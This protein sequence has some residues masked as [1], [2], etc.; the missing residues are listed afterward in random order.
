MVGFMDPDRVFRDVVSRHEPLLCE[1][2]NPREMLPFFKEMLTK[3]AVEEITCEQEQRGEYMAVPKLMSEVKRR[4]GWFP[5]FIRALLA[6]G[7]EDVADT[8][9]PGPNHTVP[10]PTDGA[11]AGPATQNSPFGA[12][13]GQPQASQSPGTSREERTDGQPP[14]E[15][16]VPHSIQ[17]TQ[18]HQRPDHG[19]GTVV[20]EEEDAEKKDGG[21]DR[22]DK[23]EDMPSL[24]DCSVSSE[25]QH[26]FIRR[27]VDDDHRAPGR[28]YADAEDKPTEGTEDGAAGEESTALFVE[29][30][31]D[32]R[33]ESPQEP[34]ALIREIQEEN[35]QKIREKEAQLES[36]KSEVQSEAERGR[37]GTPIPFLMQKEHDARQAQS[38]TD[39]EED[40]G[41]SCSS[42]ELPPG[43][44]DSVEDHWNL[45]ETESPPPNNELSSPPDRPDETL[46]KIDNITRAER[47]GKS[48]K[49][50]PVEGATGVA[51]I[52]GAG[53]RV[54]TATVCDGRE[55]ELS[56]EPKEPVQPSDNGDGVHDDGMNDYLTKAPHATLSGTVATTAPKD[57]KDDASPADA[58]PTD[59]PTRSKASTPNKPKARESASKPNQDGKH[60]PSDTCPRKPPPPTSTPQTTKRPH[61]IPER[62]AEENNSQNANRDTDQKPSME[63][64][65]GFGVDSA[66]VFSVAGFLLAAGV[67]IYRM[68]FM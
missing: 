68:R 39:K 15:P 57:T 6:L 43:F 35:M 26:H 36:V 59:L 8:L 11:T 23:D 24:E 56:T 37:S 33:D 58:Q 66:T 65:A 63:K 52:S 53:K 3:R 55:N 48:E 19:Q 22:D 10:R 32:H 4:R 40:E 7:H 30:A 1:T 41:S 13:A 34:G 9:D 29:P 27:R 42:F 46:Q 61:T 62:T 31:G 16:R 28:T 14:P 45:S 2:I 25:E 44:H 12:A 49:V 54:S 64:D 21:D 67:A 50:P 18:P 47:Q 51:F 20:V 17:D 5:V 38:K 60:R